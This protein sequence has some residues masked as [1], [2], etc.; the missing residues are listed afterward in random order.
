MQLDSVKEKQKLAA[1]QTIKTRYGV[2]NVSQLE[3]TQ[4]KI[5]ENSLAKYG[6]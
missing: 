5:K 1:Q 3:S 6:V 2:I 4:N